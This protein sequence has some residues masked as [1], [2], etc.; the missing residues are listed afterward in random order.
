MQHARSYAA[1]EAFAGPDPA[2]PAR[3]AFGIES[4]EIRGARI[5]VSTRDAAADPFCA[6]VRMERTDAERLPDVLIVAPVSGHYA[7]VTR[8][9]A[10]GLLPRFRVHVTDWT[11]PRHVPA[12]AG[13]F[14][15]EGN[16]ARV[17]GALRRLGP[18]C[19]AVGLCQGG[20]A[21]LAATA[22]LAREGGGPQALALLGAPID[23]LRNPTRLSRMLLMTPGAFQRSLL[24]PVPAGFAG[25]GRPVYPAWRHRAALRAYL[26][27]HLAEGGELRDKILADDGTDP[28]RFPFAEL[29]GS[30]MDIDGDFLVENTRS[31]FQR[32]DLATGGLRLGGAR[33]D[34][35]AIRRTALL[36]VEGAADDIA[37]PGQTRAAHRLCRNLPDVWRRH[38]TIPRCGHFSLFHGR[39]LRA[40]TLP[41]LG[42]FF[43]ERG[44]AA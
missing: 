31:V 12:E 21:A 5:P 9:L 18:R 23:P 38:E 6:L 42:S 34:P 19:A 43:A 27:R 4:V 32:R 41:L 17:V 29:Y 35:A 26:E 24:E 11:N 39:V 28:A 44:V 16:V 36:T 8:E 7:F 1:E 14:G 22:A 3:R 15:L 30:V 10:L 40:R 13:R 37:A 33:A 25:A 2:Q 20:V